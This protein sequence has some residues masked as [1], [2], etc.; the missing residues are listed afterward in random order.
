MLC[1]FAMCRYHVCQISMPICTSSRSIRIHE[2][3]LE[4]SI[5]LVL[6]QVQVLF[7]ICRVAN[8]EACN[9][10]RMQKWSC[11]RKTSRNVGWVN[12]LACNIPRLQKWAMLVYHAKT[13]QQMPSFG[14]PTRSL[15]VRRALRPSQESTSG[16]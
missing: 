15:V 10:S 11:W 9:I 8:T 6:V 16:Q 2:I 1:T 4:C 5:E 12:T 3:V 13:G 7:S 14:I